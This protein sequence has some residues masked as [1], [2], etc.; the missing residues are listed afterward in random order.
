MTLVDLG[1][2]VA[3]N[4]EATETET[5]EAAPIEAPPP[6][7]MAPTEEMA[8]AAE[9]AP[10][11]DTAAVDAPVPEEVTDPPLS[12]AQP[13]PV[14]TRRRVRSVSALIVAALLVAVGVF[15]TLGGVD[16]LVGHGPGASPGQPRPTASAPTSAGRL[17]LG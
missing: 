11:E 13:V 16:A 3:V 15:L 14:P 7:G 17:D 9:M 12:P 1:E 2:T 8:P 5:K 4:E 6:G 10:A